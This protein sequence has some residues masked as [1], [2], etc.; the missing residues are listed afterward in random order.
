MFGTAMDAPQQILEM[1]EEDPVTTAATQLS[2]LAEFGVCQTAARTLKLGQ[3]LGAGRLAVRDDPG[4]ETSHHGTAG[5]GVLEPRLLSALQTKIEDHFLAFFYLREVDRGL[6]L[7]AFLAE[8]D[9][10]LIL[11][12][13]LPGIDISLL[14]LR[15]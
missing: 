12:I 3:R 5:E 7:T 2:A 11:W 6:I 9:V 15:Q 10:L 1:I 8:H 14:I 4:Q 13:P